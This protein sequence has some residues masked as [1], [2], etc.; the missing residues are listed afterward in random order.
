MLSLTL[1]FFLVF[2]V[3]VVAVDVV[4]VI[5]VVVIIVVGVVGGGD[6]ALVALFDCSFV[7]TFLQWVSQSLFG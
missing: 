5:V 2:V 3:V 7:L 6:C 1:L 4:A